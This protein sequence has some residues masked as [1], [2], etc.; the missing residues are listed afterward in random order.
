MSADDVFLAR[1]AIRFRSDD[2]VRAISGA[3]AFGLEP[4]E[5]ILLVECGIVRLSRYHTY[6]QA[7]DVELFLEYMLTK[8]RI[9]RDEH[10]LLLTEHTLELMG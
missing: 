1:S 4:Q 5:I 7:N 8:G 3:S 9:D 2:E 6:F 10:D